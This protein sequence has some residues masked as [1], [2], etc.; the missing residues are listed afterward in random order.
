MSTYS[1]TATVSG[2]FMCCL[3]IPSTSLESVAEK[4]SVCRSC[5]VCRMMSRTSLMNPMS[6]ILSASSSTRNCT[7]ERLTVLLSRWSRSLPG[8]ATTMSAVRSPLICGTMDTPP[9]TSTMYVG[10]YFENVLSAIATWLQSSLVGTMMSAW[11]PFPRVTFSRMGSPK[12][13]VFPEPVCDCPKTSFPCWMSGSAFCCISVSS[14][15]P[16]SLMARSSS[17]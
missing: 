11:I 2:F 6:N 7:L 4:R 5:G 14:V 13:A 15:N 9:Y 16:N 1:C 3:A 8:V 12:A 17:G 10:L